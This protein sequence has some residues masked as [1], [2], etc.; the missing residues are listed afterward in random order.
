MFHIPKTL[1]EKENLYRRLLLFAVGLFML[2][3]YFE[4]ILWI[5]SIIVN[6]CMP[7]I[8]GGAIAFIWNTIA[9]NLINFYSLISHRSENK[10]IRFIANILSIMVFVLLLALFLF[11]I[12]PRVISS[13]QTLLSLMPQTIHNI[14]HW[15]YY[16]SK[17]IPYV[18]QWL[19][20]INAD[21]GNIS[22]VL[23]S[24]FS[25]VISGSANDIIG[26]VY[27]V[28]TN[29]F[30]LLF[31]TLISIMFAVI[32]LFNKQTVVKEGFYLMRAYLSKKRYAKTVHILSLIRNTF[33]SYIGGTCTE[34]IILATL[35]MFFA[36]L[37]QI[38]FAFLAGILVGIGALIP[39]FGALAAAII[40]AL[41][42]AVDTPI[43]GLYFIILFICIQQVEGNFIYPNV[44][45][46]S[47]GI[48]PIYV[49]IAVTL[50]A[51]VAGI[52]GMVFFIPIFSCLYQLIK[53]D[54]SKR[55]EIKDKKEGLLNE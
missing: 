38:P 21:P 23:E 13:F 19:R 53:E 54:A 4:K 14:Y 24:L 34:C 28:L 1:K 42:I 22:Q 12:M 45:G 15:A 41:L 37:F 51:N 52:L 36:S 18:H 33:T 35:V 20:T 32:V 25:W 30:S 46:K 43:E 48:P 49:M 9:N 3:L 31:S 2:V 17:P 40:A 7:F 16:A 47:V 26:N 5:V 8:I 11:L 10:V 55:I 6:I 27:S 39:M 44:V 29:T 50:G